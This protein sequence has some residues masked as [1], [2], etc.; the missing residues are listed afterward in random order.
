MHVVMRS[1]LAKGE[2][3]LRASAHKEKI[4]RVVYE[5]AKRANVRIYR[6]ANRGNH[7]HLLLLSLNPKGLARFLRAASGL[8][9]RL[10][11]KSEKGR[12]LPKGMAFWDQR[13]FSRIVSWGKEYA[14]VARYL[15][16]NTLEALGFIPYQP[17]GRQR[18][19]PWAV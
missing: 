17:R 3:S 14:G 10:V 15:L 11:M 9:A 16:Q 4:R 12:P 6:Y 5:Q 1:S 2:F 13:P 18:A 19:G 7:L 8:I